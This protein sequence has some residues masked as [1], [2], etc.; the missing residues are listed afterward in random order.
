[1][2]RTRLL[3]PLVVVILTVGAFALIAAVGRRADTARRDQLRAASVTLALDNLQSAP[4][5][6]DPAA[7]GSPLKIRRV[8]ADDETTIAQG[9]SPA[10][11]DVPAAVVRA[12]RQRLTEIIPIVASIYDAATAKGGLSARAGTTPVAQEQLTTRSASLSHE[13]AII[14]RDDARAA[15]RARLDTELATAATLGLLLTV[16]MVFYVRSVRARLQVERLAGENLRLLQASREE[17]STDALTSLGNRRAL[18]AALTAAYDQ[19][20]AP[21]EPELLMAIFDL[22]GFKQYNDSYG[23]EAGDG[24]LRRLGTRLAAVARPH[25]SAYRM[26]GDEFC[27]LV[28]CGPS[29]AEGILA[30]AAA[31]AATGGTSAAPTARRGSRPKPTAPATPCGSPIRG[32]TPT[33]APGRRPV[34]SSPMS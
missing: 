1:M 5:K 9:L 25:G 11:P 26:G 29:A 7:G 24:L 28:R 2:R 3:A 20:A 23:H 12:A 27:L 17:A 16:F 6:A 33:N 4:F 32:C 10:D 31:T 8:I 21:G 34:G 15:R 13:L 22:D 30:S 14:T 19:A 18:E